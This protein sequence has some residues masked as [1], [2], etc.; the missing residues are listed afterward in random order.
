MTIVFS[1]S[2]AHLLGIVRF[3]SS[4][5]FGHLGHTVR[6]LAQKGAQAF[7]VG[8][9]VPLVGVDVFQH[10]PPGLSVAVTP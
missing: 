8:K 3:F 2:I 4:R 7:E 10:R 5:S 1:T 9:A 6:L